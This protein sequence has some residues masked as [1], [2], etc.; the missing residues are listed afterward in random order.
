VT[1]RF[2]PVSVAIRG[3][4]GIADRTVIDDI[5]QL[6]RSGLEARGEAPD[7]I[8]VSLLEP[9]QFVI[10]KKRTRRKK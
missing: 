4:I 5:N 3:D 7:R 10:Q 2:F 8:E 6:I 9:G 1:L